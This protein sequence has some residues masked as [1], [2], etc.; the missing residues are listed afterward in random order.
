MYITDQAADEVVAKNVKLQDAVRG[1]TVMLVLPGHGAYVFANL[2][3]M[4]GWMSSGLG[5]YGIAGNTQAALPYC[6][7]VTLLGVTVMSIL[8]YRLLRGTAAARRQIYIYTVGV[9]VLSAMV[10]L[11]ALVRWERPSL[12][13]ASVGLLASALAARSV[14]GPSYAALAAFFRAKRAWGESVREELQRV[15]RG[16]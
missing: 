3:L 2:G 4:L 7:L 12:V 6:M 11:I 8:V 13:V 14:A 5:A 9:A 15:R 1:K 10:A 16:A